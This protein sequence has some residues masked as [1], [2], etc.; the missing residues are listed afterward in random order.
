MLRF[1]P[2][3]LHHGHGSTGDGARRALVLR[4]VDESC[5]PRLHPVRPLTKA[6]HQRSPNTPYTPPR[7]SVTTQ[8]EAGAAKDVYI[9]GDTGET[10]P[11]LA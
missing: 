3:H 6:F 10:H 11:G 7:S 8:R 4:F 2:E 1:Q 9:V 5:D